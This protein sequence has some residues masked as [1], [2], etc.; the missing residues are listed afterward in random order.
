[1]ERGRTN[2][3]RPFNVR[4]R[5][6]SCKHDT[7]W[8]LQ[9]RHGMRHLRSNQ[10]NSVQLLC[11]LPCISDFVWYIF[12]QSR[13]T[14][15]EQTDPICLVWIREHI[16]SKTFTL[17]K[18]LVSKNLYEPNLKINTT[19]KVSSSEN[20]QLLFKQKILESWEYESHHY[21]LNIINC[22]C[23]HGIFK[24]NTLSLKAQAKKSLS[25]FEMYP[26]IS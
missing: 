4:W 6:S 16:N 11:A 14:P 8:W 17:L 10:I 5:L 2:T 15:Y 20:H 7:S 9:S 1:M 19:L 22:M 18:C 23:G 12:K 26:V 21:N 13:V 25:R 3:N 24:F